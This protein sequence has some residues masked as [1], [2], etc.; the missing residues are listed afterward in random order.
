MP[1]SKNRPAST[2]PPER[3]SHG[4]LWAAERR[5]QLLA[6]AS[7]LLSEKGIEAVR[8]PTVAQAAG[9]TRPVVY[10]HFENRNALLA[11]LLG[12]FGHQL[13]ARLTQAYANH[14]DNLY[15]TLE[16]A[17]FAV[18]ET[19][20]EHGAGPWFLIT[21]N[22]PDPEISAITRAL[23][24]ELVSPWLAD[25]QAVLG[26]SEREAFTLSQMILANMRSLILLWKQSQLTRDEAVE[27]MMRSVGAIL[28]EYSN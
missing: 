9:V 18:C 4:R 19:I 20:D 1:A 7:K 14:S 16:E 23:R 22:A 13:Q 12:D 5:K 15:F 28:R 21:G 26:V 24:D 6:I 8:I 2:S 27:N 25:L 3:P 11:E 10:K 17:M